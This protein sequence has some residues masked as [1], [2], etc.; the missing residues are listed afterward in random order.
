MGLNLCTISLK[1]CFTECCF[2]FFLISLCFSDGIYKYFVF[3]FCCV[4]EFSFLN[5]LFSQICKL[6]TF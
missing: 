2:T 4:Y 6:P 1:E 5:F 3:F